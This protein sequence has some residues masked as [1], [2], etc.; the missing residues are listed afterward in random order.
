MGGDIRRQA[1]PG[2]PQRAWLQ[3]APTGPPGE[4]AEGDDRRHEGPAAA[5]D[6]GGGG[7]AQASRGGGAVIP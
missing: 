7:L 5:A 3:A 1:H 4:A 6:L 2:L